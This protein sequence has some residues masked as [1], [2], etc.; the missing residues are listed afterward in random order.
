MWEFLGYGVIG[1]RNTV[2]TNEDFCFDKWLM[3]VVRDYIWGDLFFTIVHLPSRVIGQWNR[4][5]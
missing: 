4:R 5:D 2:M 1:E 3:R